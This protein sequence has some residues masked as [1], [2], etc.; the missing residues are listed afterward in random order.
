MIGNVDDAYSCTAGTCSRRNLIFNRDSVC[1]GGEQAFP[2]VPVFGVCGGGEQAFPVVPVFA[3]II[4]ASFCPRQV[5]LFA[6]AA[7][8]TFQGRSTV[9]YIVRR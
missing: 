9:C 7:C 8:T 4:G 1:G 6:T 3:A 2:V 5:S